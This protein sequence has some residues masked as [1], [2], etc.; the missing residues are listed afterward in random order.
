MTE[1]RSKQPA[2]WLALESPGSGGSWGCR[3]ESVGVKLPAGRLTT[4][5]LMSRTSHPT[6]IQLERL[7]GIHERHVVGPG[8]NSFTLAAG[9]ARDCLAHSQ[10][11]ARD[12]QML[13]S[14]SITRS[15]GRYT[16]SFEPPLSLYVKQAIGAAQAA[17]FDLSNACAGMLTGVFVLQNLVAQGQISCGMVVSG[18]YISHLSWNAARQ[19]RSLFSKQLASLTL[20]DAGAAVIVERAPSG[21]GIDVI[22]FTTLAEH[23]RLCLAFPSTAGPGAQM[24]TKSRTLQEVAIDDM[25]PLVAEAIGEAG[26]D[27]TDIDFMIPHQTSARAIRAG[28]QEFVRRLGARPKHVV[29]N[30]EEFGNTSSTTLFVALHKYLEEQRIHNGDRVMLL[31]LASGIEIGMAIFTVD[32]QVDRYGHTH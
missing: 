10:H 25:A 11:Q 8:E 24:Y 7:T 14:T 1:I 6:R 28:T 2:H 31:A 20:G 4:K 30:L 3:I 27:L 26:I 18:E 22:G 5:D 19:I 15:R 21:A 32:S 16:Q 9:A 29:V 13:I 17:N 12:I 23:S